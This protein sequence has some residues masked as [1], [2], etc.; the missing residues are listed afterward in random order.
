MDQ[1]FPENF[2]SAVVTVTYRDYGWTVSVAKH[3]TGA[4]GYSKRHN[5]SYRG[6]T[7]RETMDV[8]AEELT[9]LADTV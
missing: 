9:P 1:L 4:K 7:W 2:D 6:L 8:L 5:A 3:V